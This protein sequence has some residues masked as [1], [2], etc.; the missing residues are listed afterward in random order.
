V[1]SLKQA[2]IKVWMLTGDKIET[3]CCIGISSGLKSRSE[4]YYVV[5]EIQDDRLII[6]NE[7]KVRE[8]KILESGDT[9]KCSISYRWFKCREMLKIQ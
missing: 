1:E 6:E 5:R 8:C 9:E 2:G 3:A 7:L 4:K